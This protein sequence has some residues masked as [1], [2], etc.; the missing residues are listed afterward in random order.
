MSI[1]VDIL[2]QTVGVEL[3]SKTVA[4]RNACTGIIAE[5]PLHHAGLNEL[6][7]RTIEP[8]GVK[9]GE[10]QIMGLLSLRWAADKVNWQNTGQQIIGL[11]LPER[12][13][14][15]YTDDR[16]IRWMGPD[17]WLF[18]C[19]LA[20]VYQLEVDLH[21]AID[22]PHSIVNISGGYTILQLSGPKALDVLRKSTS[23]DVHISHFPPGKVVNTTFA[24]STCTLRCLAT[25]HF[26][27]IVRRSYADYIWLWLQN[28]AREY[29]LQIV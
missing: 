5:S 22:A 12:L 20:E 25:D 28:A 27:L 9:L 17:E 2:N 29:G 26:E 8:A 11:A 13:S 16:C 4:N 7:E 18:S 14:C 19:S 1:N 6:A 24:K 21:S 3:V 15:E 23:Y 10:Q